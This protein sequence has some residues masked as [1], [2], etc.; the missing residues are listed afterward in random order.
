MLSGGSRRRLESAG[1]GGVVVA[2]FGC[3]VHAA[4]L[5][6]R[7]EVA[8]RFNSMEPVEQQPASWIGGTTFCKAGTSEVR[9][10]QTVLGAWCAR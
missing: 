1:G 3:E 9:T 8:I 5:G 10:R 6:Q 7:R 2:H 4:C